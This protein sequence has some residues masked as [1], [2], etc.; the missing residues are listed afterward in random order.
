M[1][2]ERQILKLSRQIENS[3]RLFKSQRH[4]SHL[5]NKTPNIFGY[6]WLVIMCVYAVYF[7]VI[8]F[9]YTHTKHTVTEW[10]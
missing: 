10:Q 3:N 2:F 6:E 1:L 4:K 8:T 5:Q 7:L 9:Y